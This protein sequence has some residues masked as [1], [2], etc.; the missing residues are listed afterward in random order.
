MAYRLT[1]YDRRVQAELIRKEREARYASRYPTYKK[2]GAATV[3]PIRDEKEKNGFVTA[4]HTT[5]DVFAN[6]GI[7]LGKG[8]EG[9]VD[10]FAGLGGAVAGVFDDDAQKAVKDWISTDWTGE[11]YGNAWQEG[12]DQSAL[13]GT[14]VGQIVEGVAQG[15]GQL[16]PAVAVSF[17]TAGAGAPAAVAQLASLGTT[18]ASAAG[19][20]TE[21]AFQEGA[22]YGK[23]MAYGVASGAIE[24]ATEKLT[25]GL[26][27]LFGDG[28][29]IGSKAAK[30]VGK[31]VAEV[32]IKRAAKEALGEGVEEMISEA[33]NPAL[34]TIYKGKDA[35]KEYSDE[36]FWGGVLEA[37]VVGM[38]TS[39]AY[40]G[41]V[42]RAMKTTGVYADA[43][44]VAEHIEQQ[45]KLRSKAGLSQADKV[46]IEQ[47]IKR[48]QEVLSER[49]Q[50]LSE[51]KRAKV[52]ERMP[53]FKV[54]FEA[55]GTIKAEQKAALDAKIKAAG[56]TTYDARY[57]TAT[58]GTETIEKALKNG[59]TEGHEM[60]AFSGELSKEQSRAL[61][62]VHEL[63]GAVSERSG[64]ALGGFVITETSPKDGAYFDPD[65]RVVT[66]G[67]DVLTDGNASEAVSRALE[68]D[69]TLGTIVHEVGHGI[70]ETTAG[71][72]L[73]KLVTDDKTLHD[74][75]ITD[76]L[77]R[78]YLQDFFG[79]D[80][81]KA[82][83]KTVADGVAKLIEM[84]NNGEVLTESEQEA[85]DEYRDEVAAF[86]N[87][88]LLGNKAFMKK[89]ITTEPSTAEMLIAK[90]REIRENLMIR[91]PSAKAQLE[92]VRKA[93][94]LFMQGLS[95]AGGTIDATGKIHLANREED[96]AEALTRENSE[97]THISDAEG[98]ENAAEA[99]SSE[100]EKSPAKGGVRRL[101][102]SVFDYRNE[103][104]YSY[105]YLTSQQ[106]MVVAKLPEIAEIVNASGKIVRSDIVE[107]ALKNAQKNGRKEGDA[108]LVTNNYSKRP[109]R[110]TIESIRHSLG[111]DRNRLLTNARVVSIVG[112]IVKNGIPINELTN[113]SDVAEGTYAIAT[114]SEDSQGNNYVSIA[115]IEVRTNAV[116]SI[117]D[118]DVTHSVSARQKNNRDARSDTKSQGTNPPTSI[119]GTISI[120]DFLQ[121]VNTTYQSI[122]SDDVLKKMGSQRNPE[123]YYAKRVKHSR[124]QTGDSVRISTGTLAKLKANY[125][126]E[127]VFDKTKI[128][129]ALMEIEGVAELKPATFNRLVDQL[130]KGFN[131][132]MGWNGY[133]LQAEVVWDHIHT[134]ILE[135]AGDYLLDQ[136][137]RYKEPVLMK[138]ET[139]IT[140]A[141]QRIIREG[142]PSKAAQQ[143][144]NM[145]RLQKEAN[146]WRDEHDRVAERAKAMPKLA[147]ELQRLADLKKGLYVNAANYHGDDF[148]VAIDE[149]AKMNWRG[150][151]VND[152]KIREH[153]AKLAAWYTK[154]NPLYKGDGGTGSLFRQEI[155]DV[156][157]SLGNSQNGALTVEDLQAAETVAKY[158]VHEIE[159]H[160]TV[161]KDG[162]RVDAM[163]EAK[164]YIEKA[165]RAKEIAAK[166]G[167][168]SNLMRSKFARMV[169]DPAMLM[170]QADGYL[171]GF[172]TEQ[173][174]ALRQGT[175]DA[176]VL[177][178]ELSEEF[179][180]FW[181]EHKAYAKRYNDATVKF[182][183]T[184]MPLQEAISL[185]M[186]M[187]R[188]H[189]FA[190]LAG[191]GFEI[192]GK[193]ATE[194]ISD[195]FADEVNR[196]LAED[197]KALPP[198]ELLTLT[199]KKNA[200]MERSAL[201][202]VIE[203]KRQALYD[204]FTAEDREL[205]AL[206]E[207][208]FEQCRDVKV[209]IDEIVQGYSN[210]TG[211]YYY[212]IRRTG[213]AENVDAYTGFEG[214]RVTNLSM[215]QET[216]KNAHKLYI[217]PAHIVFMRHLKATSL[218]HGLGVFTDN[219]NRLYN[220]NIGSNANNPI[221]VRTALGQSTKFTQEMV[222][223]FKELKQ[224]VEGISKKKSTD[225]TNAVAFIRSMYA[226]YQLGANPKVWVT[227][228]SS[229]IAATNIIDADCLAKGLSVS[230]KDVDEFCRLAWLRNNDSSAAQAQA[231]G[232][233]Q[234]AVQRASRNVLQKVRDVAMLPIGKVDRLVITRL[235]G[236]CQVQVEKKGGAKVGTKENKIEAGKL[237]QRVILETQ[238]NSLA[239][240]RSGWMR[241]DNELVKGLTMFSADAMKVGARF[242]DAFGELSV[243]RT[244]YR[245]AKKAGNSKDMA[246]LEGEIKR[247][248]K[249]CVRATVSL[250]GVA[251]F[252]AA[253]AYGF[254][255]LYRRDEDESLGSFIA[256]TFGNMLGGIPFVR[257]LWSFFQDGFEMDHFL[258]ST[259]NDVLGTVSASFELVSDAASG[260]EV[261]RQQ[262]LA[263]M[264]KVVYAAGQ[265]SGVPT[266]NLYNFTTGVINRV[267]PEA[268]YAVESNFYKQSYA[269]DLQKALD[270]GDDKMVGT[271][272]GLMIDEKIGIE[273]AATRKTLQDLTGKGYKV[274]PRSVG[275]SVTVDGET[276]KL[277][278]AQQKKLREVY[279]IGQDAVADMVKLK[280]FAEADE[281]VQAAA[282]K[283]I[284]DVYWD[285]ALEDALGVD[286]A[287]KNVLFAEAIDI[288]KLAI[289]VAMARSIEA[290]KD[291]NGKAISGTRKRKLQTFVNSLRLSAAEKYMVMGYLGYS[292]VNGESAVKAHI[293]KL[294]LSKSEKAAL[295]KYSGYGA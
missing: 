22:S 143:Q 26:G 160:N 103:E 13:N 76:V 58:L 259:V 9:I 43:R 105:E 24:G 229:L 201:K 231:V 25:G 56:D 74:L 289:I 8:V 250:V 275:D 253:L 172:F 177:E 200:E 270:A 243:L 134:T 57:R 84:E 15:V 279:A 102:S 82:D 47:N 260:K 77:G 255:W 117:T 167:I 230:G 284:Y 91:N 262:V 276:V 66:I 46:Q 153:F 188:E 146:H 127:K 155:A 145:D 126:G 271:I 248:R 97:K 86:A 196:Q 121:I 129:N 111:G 49:L 258:I 138:M 218:Y 88:R 14:K 29:K 50:K 195:G 180:K 224:D 156:L 267:S 213:L 227:Q 268:G 171:S 2:T 114:L 52:L 237:L 100:K 166:C 139:Q 94:K 115:T 128:A 215:N 246:R 131:G 59:S 280:Q 206:M 157:N 251:L 219:F 269:S 144:A 147:H 290:D 69:G 135:E 242:V 11:L 87:Q 161:F 10:L 51:T 287:E 187:K 33:A 194:N 61:G 249:Q 228:L 110:V 282:I 20:G 204:Q 197:W 78:G 272:A 212:P 55:D 38:G 36:E 193:K 89:L 220:L 203:K 186:T 62:K 236:A 175:I 291:K 53:T 210:V 70:E 122:L 106:D 184:E 209:K 31:E 216:V 154:D 35:L 263:N 264:R 4:L 37:G 278:G 239:T 71:K 45:K 28:V 261:T 159:A 107:L 142:R 169:A 95:E 170:R 112:E 44:N 40:G 101:K 64:D 222:E 83:A 104:V 133:Q 293:G 265:L 42:G 148:K 85:L 141:L 27:G 274:L 234:N 273:D 118:Y 292:N 189:A 202:T 192:D 240:E 19:T 283:F 93:E 223:Y 162:K 18:I 80:G 226:T 23:G 16:L 286:L 54:M 256:D 39:A 108:I 150:G 173:Y 244:L 199:K 285:L 79:K 179:E 295:L 288:E 17:A 72:A 232:T 182:G 176:A 190:G 266:R 96:D 68:K 136:E 132:R 254:K 252:N 185:F 48:D 113:T 151:L 123:G 245:E 5:G 163:P 120:A 130:W 205:I 34:K 140:D 30:S 238:Q 277:T 198:E 158:F 116:L 217:E 164:D 63:M 124:K 75:A 92:L 1:P 294:N 165:R 221:T 207:R 41:T 6:V 81:K 7:G 183:D 174:E 168:W 149:L 60:R 137:Y 12:L 241:S 3:A 98:A 191:A 257:D 32:G 178:R 247:A 99:A 208:A 109:C 214:D 152:T 281:K 119:S 21:Q 67:V 235:F 65:T 90:I 233:S 181:E 125:H 225:P 73:A 211:G